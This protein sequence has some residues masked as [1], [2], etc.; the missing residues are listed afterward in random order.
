MFLLLAPFYRIDRREQE[1]NSE[2][3]EAIIFQLKEDISCI[4]IFSS[5]S[6]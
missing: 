5:T 2:Q 4:Y 1:A 6:D 3:Q